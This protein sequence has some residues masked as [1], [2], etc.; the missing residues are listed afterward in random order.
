VTRI[1]AALDGG[2]ATGPVLATASAAGRLL[3]AAVGALHVR[4]NG[5]EP[6]ARD[7]A[8]A[9]GASFEVLEGP[10]FA[11]LAEAA[12]ADDV[13]AVVVGARRT[14]AAPQLEQTGARLA[15][16]AG[17]PV[18]IVPPDAGRPDRLRNV[19]VPLQGRTPTSFAPRR[20]IDLV[21]PGELE[22]VALRA[23]EEASIPAFTDQPQHQ[24]AA[25]AQEF[26]ARYAT[27]D[28]RHVALELRVGD[29]ADAVVALAGELDPDLVALAWHEELVPGSG[30][31]VDALL[32]ETRIPLLL[33]PVSRPPA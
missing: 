1:I 29:L 24:T 12:R 9:A 18:F 23:F 11:R 7:L 19:L 4:V 10:A 6:A 3:G 22:I 32:R 13:A 27:V 15:T 8:R 21:R 16:D 17:V 30:R 26:L 33:D 5:G 20:L 31:L 2:A 25:W 28:P 14:R